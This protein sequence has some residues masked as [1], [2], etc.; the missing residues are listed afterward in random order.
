MAGI[1]YGL[2]PKN[3][4]REIKKYI[5]NGGRF[6]FAPDGSKY[7]PISIEER[8]KQI[9]QKCNEG[10]QTYELAE[11]FHLTKRTIRRILKK[12]GLTDEP[13]KKK[14]RKEMLREYL[15]IYTKKEIAKRLGISRTR[16]YQIMKEE[17]LK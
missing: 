5:P 11:L 14:P 2:L 7:N 3:L 4:N 16:L 1:I 13:Y 8:N 6:R 12:N 10:L 9:C 17:R 15:G